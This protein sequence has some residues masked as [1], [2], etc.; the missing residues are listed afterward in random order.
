MPCRHFLF[1]CVVCLSL[2]LACLLA[3][4]GR[5]DG[6]L[7][8]SVRTLLPLGLPVAEVVTVDS[9]EPTYEEAVK[10]DS[11]VTGLTIMNATK[12]PGR[13]RVWEPDGN[14]RFD[15]GADADSLD[16]MT[17][18]VRGNNSALQP[19]KPYKVK[20]RHKADLLCRGNERHYA[21]K[22]WLLLKEKQ[23]SLNIPIGFK[24]NELLDFA[25]T[26]AY[27]YVNLL[28]NGEFRGVY[29]LTEQV[30][31]A[32]CRIDVDEQTGFIIERDIYWWVEGTLSFESKLYH[33]F[34][35]RY[36]FKYPEQEDV[37]EADLG[38][39]RTA[40]N[41]M[42]DAVARGEGYSEYMDVN[43]FASWTLGHD[44]LGTKDSG[45]A[46]R[47]LVKYDNTPDSKFCMGP[48]WDF[49]SNFGTA[50]VWT[51]LH[52]DWVGYAR[53]LFP[54]KDRT[55]AYAYIHAW[56]RMYPLLRERMFPF[57]D[58]LA[59]SPTGVAIDRSW[60]EEARFRQ[61]PYV[62]VADNV[63]KAKAWFSD[64][65]YWINSHLGEV[66][67]MGIQVG[68]EDLAARNT[69]PVQCFDLM[70]HRLRGRPKAGLYI[71]GGLLKHAR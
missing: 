33:G 11:F 52:T 27:E 58:S 39:I 43:S 23:F 28:F 47:Y 62:S 17:I 4:A 26:P 40:V 2:W 60:Q 7:P 1:R 3:V 53:R 57:L 37:T 56:E 66:D 16:G 36:T 64:R 6:C 34:W 32:S 42:E 8:T 48:L 68:V 71:E 41:E 18:R 65:E 14:L 22:N 61:R 21:D 35:Q 20:L 69:V 24:V 51:E 50:G 19:L 49:D 38:Y 70:G 44:L 46:N 45:G 12:V 25:W 54:A 15:S 67:E 55:Y 9:I 30:R 31:R 5:A 10:P 13:L 59:I 63:A 29:L